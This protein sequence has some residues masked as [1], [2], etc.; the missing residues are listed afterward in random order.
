MKSRIFEDFGIK[1]GGFFE[2]FPLI[3]DGF[4]GK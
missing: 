2:G 1:K 3:G 4:W